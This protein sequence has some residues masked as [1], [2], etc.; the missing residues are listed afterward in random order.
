HSSVLAALLLWSGRLRPALRPPFSSRSG[1]SPFPRGPTAASPPPNRSVHKLG[2]W[3]ALLAVVALLAVSDRSGVE[4]FKAYLC[5]HADPST[6]RQQ[7]QDLRTTLGTEAKFIVVVVCN[8]LWQKV[9]RLS[10]Q[11]VWPPPRSTASIS[12][13]ALLPHS[14][15]P[16]A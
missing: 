11:R 3:A 4:G 1:R 10:F 7:L 9:R 12:R 6:S 14:V 16:Q 5:L 8:L 15:L 2:I 13:A